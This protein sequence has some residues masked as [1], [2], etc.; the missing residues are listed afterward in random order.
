MDEKDVMG[1]RCSHEGHAEI[2]GFRQGV[3]F[4]MRYGKHITKRYFKNYLEKFPSDHDAALRSTKSVLAITCSCCHKNLAPDDA[5]FTCPKCHGQYCLRCDS[6]VSE[7]GLCR[8]CS[9]KYEPANDDPRTAI[10]NSLLNDPGV[11][12]DK[13]TEIRKVLNIEVPF[14]D[15][16]AKVIAELEECTRIGRS[17]AGAAESRAKYAISGLLLADGYSRIVD[18]WFSVPRGC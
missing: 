3:R 1:V 2:H 5:W 11:S 14:G 4:G 17:D 9:E 13:K 16:E 18:L 6:D 10:L 15:I 8:T 12:A 7:S